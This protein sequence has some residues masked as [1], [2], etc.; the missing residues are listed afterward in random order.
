MR[1]TI[2]D[3]VEAVLQNAEQR[4]KLVEH[5]S[6]GQAVVFTVGGE[7]FRLARRRNVTAP[8]ARTGNGTKP[9]ESPA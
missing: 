5:L 9:A 2:S 8:P 4:E 1:A 7:T 3:A 6:S